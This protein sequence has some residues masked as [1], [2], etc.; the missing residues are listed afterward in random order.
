MRFIV[1]LLPLL[2]KSSMPAHI[3]SVVNFNLE[4]K[5][6]PDDLALRKPG[7]IGMS[8]SGPHMAHMNSL[9]MEQLA[10]RHPDRL[11]LIH[12]YPGFVKTKIAANGKFPKWLAWIW[13]YVFEPLFSSIFVPNEECGERLVNLATSRYPA[14]SAE[15]TD[16]GP[17][18]NGGTAL[19]PDGTI[20][21][22]FYRVNWNGDSIALRKAQKVVHE[23]GI[24]KK[25]WDHT[26]DVFEAIESGGKSIN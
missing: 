13:I 20:G 4:G 14:H 16:S 19:S 10:V 8:S 18:R 5:L 7:S 3:V 23:G 11:A 2:L 21:G 24:P 12:L 1:Q 9:F 6:N 25:A 26:M 15:R 17:S 22:G